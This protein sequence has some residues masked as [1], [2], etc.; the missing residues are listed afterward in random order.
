M[1]YRSSTKPKKLG[2][3]I[4]FEGVD[5]VGKTTLSRATASAI[6]ARGIT[7]SEVSFPGKVSGTLG[8]YVYDLHHRPTDHAIS[9]ISSESLQL[10][11][12]AAHFDTLEKNI[13]PALLAGETVI[14]D[15]YWWSTLAYG[16]AGNIES[17]LIEKMIELEKIKWGDILPNCV[18]YICRK[19]PLKEVSDVKHWH[20]VVK[21]YS[22]I[23]KIEREAYH[24]IEIPNEGNVES[25][26]DDVL[27]NLDKL[28]LFNKGSEHGSSKSVI[29][30]SIN[31]HVSITPAK[32]TI[33]YDSYWKFAAERQRVFFRRMTMPFGPWTTDSIIAEH[34]FTNAYRAS[35]RVSQFLIRNV[36]YSGDQ[37]PDEVFFRTLV[38][39]TF[40]KIS[41]WQLLE[42]ELGE[43]KYENFRFSD[44]DNVLT[45]AMSLGRTIYS[46]A[47]IMTSGRSAF[48]SEK[49][50]RNH[51]M[52]IETMMKDEL[53]ARIAEGKSMAEL[54]DLLLSYPTLGDF[55]AYQYAIDLNYSS[56]VNY[57][58]REFVVPGPGAKDG[59]RKCFSDFG[60]LNEADIIR[61][62]TDRQ[63][64]EFERLGIEFP[65]LW[66]RD[67]QLIDCQNL[68]C[69]VDK[70][71][72]IK[73]PEVRGIS[74]RSR[75]KQKHRP[76]DQPIHYWY[77]PTWGINEAVQKGVPY[78]P[79][80]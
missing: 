29:E 51:L 23:C 69:E 68:F 59:L 49:K 40:N 60:G 19:Q 58:E 70:Y 21:E 39:K 28:N 45:Q 22:A 26:L 63:E 77:P 55:L 56:I 34:K 50:H 9:H 33:V 72:R 79:S 46:A 64:I 11:H 38:F 4:V 20:R 67:L 36:Q 43:L 78:V 35:D 61:L 76:N 25:A 15:R 13:L 7:V 17:V 37:S 18:F 48:G 75:I 62:V 14:L 65:S 47:Y 5:E 1:K 30:T 24:V 31:I 71:A 73:H 44:Y 8:S 57:S 10:L 27:S 74:G 6:R 32:P 53:P 3:L 2:N 54:F 80:I 16:K 12:L 42:A 41:T 52:L 66:G